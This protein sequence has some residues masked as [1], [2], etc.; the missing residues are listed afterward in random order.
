MSD[1]VPVHFDQGLPDPTRFPVA[2]LRACLLETLDADGAAALT[3]YGEG[4]PAEMQFG[5]LGLRRALAAWMTRR[6]DRRV[7]PDGVLLAQGSTDGLALA[8]RAHLGPADGAVLEAAT[9]PHTRRFVVA[10]GAQVATVPLD[11]DGMVVDELPGAL[12]R[13]RDDGVRPR[14]IATIPSF[15]SPTGTLLPRRRR[16]RLLEIA[17]EW[18]VLVLEDNCYHAFAY[19]TPAP[20]TLLALDD[21]GRVLHSDTFS[22]SIA[23]GLRMAWVAGTPDVVAP[24]GAARQD[25]AVSQLLARALERYVE[26]GH[27]DAHLDELREAY[28]RKRDL[29]A[30]ALAAHC[31]DRARFRVPGGGF[32]FWLELAPDVDWERARALLD[33]RGIA[34]RPGE[35][36]TGEEG[37]GRRFVRVSP[38]QVPDAEIEPGI[39]E[40]GRALRDA[41]GPG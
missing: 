11:D 29:T 5:A 39:V 35:M 30:A 4:G 38:I 13:L 23:P 8:V 12:A 26:R 6:D 16:E 20:P 15:H 24:L 22:K 14:M 33:E 28:R 10:T 37:A 41:S 21:D 18:D 19:D 3:Y 1:R 31:G 7:D 34:C 27:L 2:V 25:F 17:R 32:Y 9:Y 40:L 36:Y